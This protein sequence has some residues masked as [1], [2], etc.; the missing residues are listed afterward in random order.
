[1]E[2]NVFSEGRRER[3]YIYLYVQENRW[4]KSMETQ[5]NSM[6]TTLHAGLGL[7][8]IDIHVALNPVKS[9]SPSSDMKLNKK[10]ILALEK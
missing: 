8:D 3:K 10:S 9:K 6:R 7:Y 1:M 2:G 5:F 4:I